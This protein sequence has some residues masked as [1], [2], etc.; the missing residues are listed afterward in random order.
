MVDWGKYEEWFRIQGSRAGGALDEDSWT[1]AKRDLRFLE[2]EGFDLEAVTPQQFSLWVIRRLDAKTFQK[3]R[4]N[5]LRTEMLRWFTYRDGVRPVLPR[6]RPEDSKEKAL[7]REGKFTA[8]GYE[9]DDRRLT[10]RRRF[11][12]YFA[13]LTGT[14]PGEA[15]YVEETDFDADLGGVH[16]LHPIKG[17]ARRF[18][19]LPKSFWS[20]RRPGITTWLRWR[21]V[22]ERHPAAVFTG[23]P[24]RWGAPKRLEPSALSREMQKVAAA[25]GVWINW[26][27]T[28]H[29]FGTDL[30]EAQFGERYVMKVLGLRNMAHLPTYAEA[31]PN[32]LN[33]RYRSLKGLDPFQGRLAD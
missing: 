8:L 18:V 2:S 26:Q 17:H 13:L 23:R 31:R 4:A 7:S 10:M 19:P 1:K 16:I 5:N 25:T 29:T 33:A 11:M 6:W 12:V 27:V 22:D 24:N 32:A 3:G 28:R 21:E 15:A 20:P 9:C 30:L 14:E